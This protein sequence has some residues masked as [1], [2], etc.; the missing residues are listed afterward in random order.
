MVLTCKILLER[1]GS[2]WGSEM[3]DIVV[4]A[5]AAVE[6]WASDLRKAVVMGCQL[7]GPSEERE[8]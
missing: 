1:S 6:A 7:G 8:S 4:Y 5:C 3:K 2:V